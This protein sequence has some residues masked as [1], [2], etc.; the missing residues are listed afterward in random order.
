MAGSQHLKAIDLNRLMEFNIQTHIIYW[1]VIVF[2]WPL[3]YFIADGEFWDP[4]IN[5]LGY[6]PSQL[7]VS[8]V[9]IYYLLPRLFSRRLWSFFGGLLLVTYV[10]TV[11]ARF[12]KIYFY[13]TIVGFQSDKES[14]LEILTQ[15]DPLLIQYL[16]W[17]LMVPALTIIIVLVYSHFS[18]KKLLAELEYEKAQ[19]ELNFLKAQLHPHFLFNTLNN[20]YALAVQGSDQTKGVAQG[21]KKLLSHIFD[22]SKGAVIPLSQELELLGTYVSLEKLRYGDRLSYYQDINLPS[23]NLFIL[24]MVL[25]SILENAFKHGVSGDLNAPYIRVDINHDENMIRF[26]IENSVPQETPTDQDEYTKGIGVKNIKRQ[27]ELIYGDHFNYE[28]DS[29]QS[30]YKVLLTIDRREMRNMAGFIASSQQ[31]V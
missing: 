30:S 11:L 4:L 24:P 18:Q 13:E 10:A 31:M 17:V 12:M 23:E 8:Y 7:L 22:K 29:N 3:L 28:V 16:I 26:V 25:L 9:F 20:L 27:L 2:F 1:L 6:L 21:L 19:T 15:Q 5:K 14:I